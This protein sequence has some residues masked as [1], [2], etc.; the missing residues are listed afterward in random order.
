MVFEHNGFS[1]VGVIGIGKRKD[2]SICRHVDHSR[3]MDS[4]LRI[5]RGGNDTV[6]VNRVIVVETKAGHI[7]KEGMT[8]ASPA[9]QRRPDNKKGFEVVPGDDCPRITAQ[10]QCQSGRLVGQS[11]VNV[12]RCGRKR[13]GVGGLV[14]VKRGFPCERGRLFPVIS[15]DRQPD[16]LSILI[17]REEILTGTIRAIGQVE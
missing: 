7:P 5:D 14:K 4:P 9:S 16:I 2:C 3:V 8:A 17:E 12:H 1:A 10:K 13:L 15:L 6:S 11:H